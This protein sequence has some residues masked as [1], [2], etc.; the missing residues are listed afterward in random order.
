[1]VNNV[2]NSVYKYFNH[3][4]NTGYFR[5]SNVNRLLLYIGIQELLDNDFRG[6]VSEED[7]NEI[8]K[9][10]Y[11]L[12]GSS[13]LIPYP[14]YYNTKNKR[15]MYTGSISE[16]EHRLSDLEKL[17]DYQSLFDSPIVVTDF[18][19]SSNEENSEETGD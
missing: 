5:Q 8:N 6:L 1:M 16:M 9:A 11:C 10:L 17:L 13:C 3:L 18:D 12:Y 15:T 19:E 2:Y 7:Y 14:D 4:S